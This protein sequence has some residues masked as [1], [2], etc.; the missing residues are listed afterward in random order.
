MDEE[1]LVS[2]G[3]TSLTNRIEKDNRREELLCVRWKTFAGI[4]VTPRKPFGTMLIDVGLPGRGVDLSLAKS[5]EV[6]LSKPFGTMLLGVGLAGRGAD[7]SSANSG[8]I[9][10]SKPF[11]TML[12]SVGLPGRGVEFSS[13]NSVE[14]ALSKTFD[15]MLIDVGLPGRGVDFS[16]ANSLPVLSLIGIDS[17][18]DGGSHHSIQN[19]NVTN[20]MARHEHRLTIQRYSWKQI[21]TEDI[22]PGCI[23]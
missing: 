13:A 2:S 7:F 10:L 17:R 14:L 12:I 15:T 4:E 19:H 8:K 11:D 1:D 6:A 9:A 21:A 16:S 3:N 22:S 20:A 18:S 5:G 23:L